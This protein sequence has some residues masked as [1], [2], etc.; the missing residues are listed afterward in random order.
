MAADYIK[1]QITSSP[2]KT[3]LSR[4]RNQLISALVLTSTPYAFSALL[5]HRLD[6]R[7]NGDGALPKK[8]PT[9]YRPMTGR[10]QIIAISFEASTKVTPER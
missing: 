8:C 1:L 9:R 6:S 4:I 5:R 2:K 3:W 10:G 7:P